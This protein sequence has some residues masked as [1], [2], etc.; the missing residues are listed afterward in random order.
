MSAMRMTLVEQLENY[1]ITREVAEDARQ[2]REEF[3]RLEAR[4][5]VLEGMWAEIDVALCNAERSAMERLEEMP[6]LLY[7]RLRDRLRVVF[8]DGKLK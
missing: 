3:R 7:G 2:A 6:R 8:V 4:I 5:V 1:A